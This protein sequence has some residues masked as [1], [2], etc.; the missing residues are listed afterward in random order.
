MINRLLSLSTKR[1]MTCQGKTTP[2][3]LI[4]SSN[5]TP[6][7]LPSKKNHL[8]GDKS[9]VPRPYSTETLLIGSWPSVCFLFSMFSYAKNWLYSCVMLK[10]RWPD[11]QEMLISYLIVFAGSEAMFADLGHFS[12]TAI[13]VL[14]TKAFKFT[15]LNVCLQSIVCL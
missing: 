1:T 6:P 13:Q 12:Y 5:F 9:I 15:F 4:Q 2:F 14:L 10:S 7:Y 8:G 11:C 3:K